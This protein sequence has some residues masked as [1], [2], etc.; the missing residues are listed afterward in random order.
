MNQKVCNRVEGVRSANSACAWRRDENGSYP[1]IL[2]LVPVQDLKCGMLNEMMW[3]VD[4]F[5]LLDYFQSKKRADK[6]RLLGG[7]RRCCMVVTHLP[8][9]LAC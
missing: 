8:T 6:F 7:L 1:F 3:N 9:S 2:V 5:F 4:L